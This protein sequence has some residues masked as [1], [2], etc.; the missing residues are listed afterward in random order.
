MSVHCRYSMSS[1]AK[2]LFI[3]NEDPQDGILP[4]RKTVGEGRNGV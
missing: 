2:H 1:S 3:L 4:G